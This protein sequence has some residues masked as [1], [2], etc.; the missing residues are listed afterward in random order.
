MPVITPD[1]VSE[2]YYWFDLVNSCAKTKGT[3]K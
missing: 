2:A 1:I 3:Q